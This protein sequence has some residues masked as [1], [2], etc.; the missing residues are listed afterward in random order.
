M[1]QP[2]TLRKTKGR[3]RIMTLSPEMEQRVLQAPHDAVR[4]TF[5]KFFKQITQTTGDN[6]VL[7]PDQDSRVNA[8]LDQQ[9]SPGNETST[10]ILIW[11][12]FVEGARPLDAK[13]MDQFLEV[14]SEMVLLL[15]RSPALPEPGSTHP[16]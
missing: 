3:L 7:N 14:A 12:W 4:L 5:S 13:G 11:K 9:P 10:Q 1:A 6:V 16:Q 2:Y 15:N 8:Y